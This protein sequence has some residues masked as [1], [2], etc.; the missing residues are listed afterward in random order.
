MHLFDSWVYSLS[1]AIVTIYHL[2]QVVLLSRLRQSILG[3]RPSSLR[4]LFAPSIRGTEAYGDWNLHAKL[5]IPIFCAHYSSF[6]NPLHWYYTT[7]LLTCLSSKIV[8]VARATPTTLVARGVRW[9]W[10][11]R[12]HVS[13]LGRERGTSLWCNSHFASYSTLMTVI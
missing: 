2:D 7:Q 10:K 5:G 12:M 11:R 1:V 4:L 8:L 13:S 9:K 6:Y 3:T